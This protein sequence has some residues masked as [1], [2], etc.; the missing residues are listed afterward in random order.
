MASSRCLCFRKAWQANQPSECSSQFANTLAKL[1][2]SSSFSR[3]TFSCL[4]P[5]MVHLQLNFCNQLCSPLSCILQLFGTASQSVL[6]E[7]PIQKCNQSFMRREARQLSSCR[8]RCRGGRDCW[9]WCVFTRIALMYMVP[10]SI[11]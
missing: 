6:E 2:C 7:H 1:V 10:V 8:P 9:A 3:S 5:W 4:A 11:C